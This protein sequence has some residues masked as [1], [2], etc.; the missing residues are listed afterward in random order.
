MAKS[1]D[2]K[3]KKPSPSPHH[4]PKWMKSWWFGA[5][6][7]LVPAGVAL[8]ITWLLYTRSKEGQH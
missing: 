2:D 8:L 7:I 4:P 6:T 5:L 1:D 3:G